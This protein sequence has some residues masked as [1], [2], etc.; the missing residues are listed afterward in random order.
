[1]EDEN[2]RQRMPIYEYY[3]PHCEIV[4]D[5]LR[6]MSEADEPIACPQCTGTEARRVPSCF[7]ALVKGEGGTS[8]SVAGSSACAGC[9]AT[10]CSS[11]GQR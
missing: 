4:F 6:S 9:T 2:V 1:L 3:C 5:A 11:C 8:R 7:A 10:T